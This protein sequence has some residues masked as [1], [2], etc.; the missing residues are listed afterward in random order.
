MVHHGF[1]T[2]LDL[3]CRLPQFLWWRVMAPD[4]LVDL[5]DSGVP[6]G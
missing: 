4:Q 2:A 3:V 1:Q 6:P 5:P